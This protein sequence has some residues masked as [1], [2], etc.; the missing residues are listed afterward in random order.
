M[1]ERSDAS[2]TGPRSRAVLLLL[3]AATVAFLPFRSSYPG[4]SIYP[5]EL[6]LPAHV[7]IDAFFGFIGE[8][9][10]FAFRALAAVVDR[11]LRLTQSGLLQVPWPLFTVIAAGLSWV[12]AGRGVASLTFATCIYV[13]A[14]GYWT[15]TM[16]TL[17]LV[18]VALPMTLILG[19]AMGMLLHASRKAAALGDP[20]LDF[21]Q[22][23]PAFAYLIPLVVLFGFGPVV[24]VIAS[25]VYAFPPMAR[26]MRLG[27]DQTPAEALEAARMAGCSPAQSFFLVKLP[28]AMPQALLGLNQTVMAL[29]S[30]VIFAA[31]IGGFDDL[32]WQ[33]LLSMRK[34]QFG[35]CI[36]AG[37]IITLIAII[38]DRVTQHMGR[39]DGGPA[40]GERKAALW[41]TLG[42][43]LACGILLVAFPDIMGLPG[44][45]WL[46]P[47]PA[48]DAWSTAVSTALADWSTAIKTAALYFVLIPIR[49]GLENAVTPATWGVGFSPA[50][51][52]LYALAVLVLALVLARRPLPRLVLILLGLLLFT[53][54]SG[55]PWPFFI[56]IMAMLA[57]CIDGPRLALLTGL[58]LLAIAVCGLW[59]SAMFSLYLCFAAIA[60]SIAL[61]GALGIL[62][63][64]NIHVSR[65]LRPVCDFLQTIPPFV[66]LIPI[67]MF[68]Q[69][70]DFAGFL[71]IV[72][73]SLVPMIRYSEDGLRRVPRDK[74]E[75]G[76]MAGC[77]QGQLL[78]L[79]KV[80]SAMPQILLGVNQTCMF[81]LAMLAVAALVGSRGLGQDVYVALSSASA[82][83][84]ILAGS[85][86]ALLAIIVDR[87][88][89]AC[90]RG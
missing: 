4:L 73:Y 21:A 14:T 83:N 39:R 88:L 77:T 79:I 19:V 89:R 47:A 17:T 24:G 28:S 11:V 5:A 23:V 45:R 57:W 13:V 27:L 30:M 10:Q 68:F 70:G 86:I 46:N 63:A 32:G 80:P 56:L 36:L 20:A 18:L 12:A 58:A 2:A 44:V 87:M 26:N 65:V 8:N 69:I 15:A 76:Q 90:V 22:T 43:V 74:L 42:L 71:S 84:G 52:M 3:I 62:A 33:V 60:T 48:L 38:L 54:F 16:N 40:A 67:L 6:V 31:V 29:L 64:S 55:F 9:F 49:V 7:A 66:I 72:A 81:A 61:G 50:A 1:A 85:A 35:E 25:I 59:P 82:G 34:A 78:W 37:I 51:K 53:G 75:A 41:I